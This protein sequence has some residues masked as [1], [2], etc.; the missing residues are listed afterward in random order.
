MPFGKWSSFEDC[1]AEMRGRQD[2]TDP[3]KVCGALQARLEH[4]AKSTG[5]LHISRGLVTSLCPA[6]GEEMQRLGLR[7]LRFRDLDELPPRLLEAILV[8]KATDPGF[9]RRCM[10]DAEMCAGA[11]SKE[12]CCAA[13]HEKLFGIWPGEHRSER[14]A[15]PDGYEAIER[16]VPITKVDEERRLVFS[17]V[18]EPDIADAH[19]DA[20]TIEQIERAAHGF[21]LRYARFLGDPGVEHADR[22]NREQVTVVE[23]YIAQ[24]DF[25][26]GAQR[27]RRGSWVMGMK[28]HDDTVW[29]D[30]KAGR[31]RGYSL[32]GW[33]HRRAA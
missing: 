25:T 12:G 20:M 27:V 10:D 23:S 26:L 15:P 30:V 32:Q 22:L 21:M 4:A 9:F 2:V 3:E 8:R 19:E 24:T 31:Y 33:G 5:L 1:V 29:A 28:I 13:L 17:V 6:C 14:S 11:D 16:E 7:V 18:Y